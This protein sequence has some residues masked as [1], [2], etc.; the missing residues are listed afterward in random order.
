MK[1]SGPKTLLLV[2]ML[3]IVLSVSLATVSLYTIPDKGSS[4]TRVLINETFQMSPNETYRQGLGS[5]YGDENVTVTVESSPPLPANFSLQM[6]LS[7][8]VLL[9]KTGMSYNTTQTSFSYTFPASPDYYDAVFTSTSNQT[10]TIHF[11]AL[12]QKPQV[13]YPNSW[14][15]EPS[16]ILFL[17]SLTAAILLAFKVTLS[18]FS[19]SKPVALPV[20]SKTARSTAFGA[21]PVRFSRVAFDSCV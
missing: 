10:G 16:K 7:N 17:A 14:L 15:T 21:S 3:F 2:A 5:F 4:Q 11:E 19:I 12:D 6:P 8:D 9:V 18:G 1:R 20:L 13:S